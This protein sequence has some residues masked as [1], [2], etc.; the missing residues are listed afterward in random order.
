MMGGTHT[1]NCIIITFT[2]VIVIHG[3]TQFVKHF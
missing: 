2:N 1:Y 3:L